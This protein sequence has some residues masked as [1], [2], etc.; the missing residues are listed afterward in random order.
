MEKDIKQA[1]DYFVNQHVPVSIEITNIC[2]AKCSFCW[3]GRGVDWRKPGFVSEE[4]LDRFLYLLNDHA[5]KGDVINLSTAHG[6]VL[7]CKDLP[8]TIRKITSVPGVA[9]VPFFTNA[10][11]L[12][13][14]DIDELLF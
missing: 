2:S 13:K 6:D 9:G 1:I 14:F 11:L 8:N 5:K 3:Y 12:H 4:T 10:I 7:T